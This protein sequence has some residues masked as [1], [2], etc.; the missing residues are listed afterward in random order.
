MGRTPVQLRSLCRWPGRRDR[1]PLHDRGNCRAHPSRGQSRRPA[2]TTS[3]AQRLAWSSRTRRR[4]CTSS[5]S[6]AYGPTCCPSSCPPRSGSPACWRVPA[7][8]RTHRGRPDAPN[9]HAR[10]LGV[11]GRKGCCQRGDGW[12]QTGISPRHSGAGRDGR[13]GA[14]QHDQFS[15][16]HGCCQRSRPP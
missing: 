6:R 13:L 1:P 12:G 2:A 5:L 10:G 14:G 15:R 16:V 4:T 9:G 7:A 8:A 3:T 11:H